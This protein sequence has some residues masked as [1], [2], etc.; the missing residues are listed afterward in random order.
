MRKYALRSA[1][2][3]AFL[4]H[5]VGG[6]ME[7]SDGL[8]DVEFSVSFIM[9]TDGLT[10]LLS[11]I[12]QILDNLREPVVNSEAA[13]TSRRNH[14]WSA[15]SILQFQEV[16]FIKTGCKRSGRPCLRRAGKEKEL[17]ADFSALLL[18]SQL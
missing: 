12:F 13:P 14:A 8:V 18:Y 4:L 2:F 17:G 6:R 15:D 10:Y 1:D 16:Q 9:L 11:R 5:P 3:L 7:F